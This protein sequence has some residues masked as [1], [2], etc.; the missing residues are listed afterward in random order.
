MPKK[1]KRKGMT[2]LEIII[3]I[4]MYAVLALLLTE[5]MTVVN[6]LMKSTQQ[7]DRRL[8]YEAPYA[9][10]LVTADAN[11]AF[12]ML[13]ESI[14]DPNDPTKTV[15]APAVKVSISYG[16]QRD[17]DKK[18]VKADNVISTDRSHKVLRAAEY[19]AAY[20]ETSAGVHYH[21]DTNYKFML[22]NKVTTVPTKPDGAF[23]VHLNL[24]TAK[25]ASI[26]HIKVEANFQQS[27]GS[28]KKETRTYK[29]NNTDS[30]C[31]N[32]NT[33]TDLAVNNN[34]DALGKHTTTDTVKIEV[35]EEVIAKTSG[36]NLGEKKVAEATVTFYTGI[37]VGDYPNYYEEV[38][39]DI[40][41][42]NTFAFSQPGTA[43]TVIDGE[44]IS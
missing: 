18:F 3:S 17:A 9:D 40:A 11:G 37:M 7:L 1:M 8:A 31:Y 6:T 29:P 32:L 41:D 44:T 16:I 13:E 43:E 21:D 5:I 20:N 10:N 25:L 15:K 33:A 34:A 12:T 24:S 36:N 26:D 30:S 42:N 4:A 14:T 19:T 28:Y 23:M 2:L 22:F 39:V 38:S 27:D 35:H